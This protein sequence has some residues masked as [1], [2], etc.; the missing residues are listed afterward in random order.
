M[1]GDAR[2]GYA[3]PQDPEPWI[4]DAEKPRE[5]DAIT[6]LVGLATAAVTAWL[7]SWPWSDPIAAAPMLAAIVLFAA[8]RSGVVR[9]ASTHHAI[10][11]AS[12]SIVVTLATSAFPRSGAAPLEAVD[13]ALLLFGGG[14]AGLGFASLLRRPLAVDPA[15]DLA[16]LGAESELA[17]LRGD[18]RPWRRWLAWSGVASALF[19]DT[20]LMS[21]GSTLRGLLAGAAG[22][23]FALPLSGAVAALGGLAQHA[24][25]WSPRFGAVAAGAL[26]GAAAGYVMRNARRW[27]AA[28]RERGFEERVRFEIGGLGTRVEDMTP[29]THRDLSASASMVLILAG[30]A[31]FTCALV[32][33]AG[34]ARGS[35]AAALAFA[36]LSVLSPAFIRLSARFGLVI[37][38]VTAL[39]MGALLRSSLGDAGLASLTLVPISA[40]C[41]Q[42]AAAG[43]GFRAGARIGH[44]PRKEVGLRL[45]AIAATSIL[46]CAMT[47]GSAS[48]VASRSS[49]DGASFVLAIGAAAVF[50]ALQW[51]KLPALEL[52]VGAALGPLAFPLAIG[53]V[54]RLAGLR[55]SFAFALLA[56]LG[57]GMLVASILAAVLAPSFI[58]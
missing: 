37:A 9:P 13:V 25:R 15:A 6:I 55:Q 14:A 43:E 16:F 47:V 34:L 46:C 10:A 8:A 45:A 5:I 53:A 50:G 12:S 23:A 24:L 51:S 7:V 1:I 4:G 19:F 39:G 27:A 38:A 58:S 41:M 56:A 33:R 40:A 18:F 36:A 48:V 52:A 17:S 42:A 44:T 57:V 49:L 22:G 28:Y 54:L 2:E 3:R 26:L 35:A 29:R 21:A 11:I 32:L 20:T 31:S 30:C